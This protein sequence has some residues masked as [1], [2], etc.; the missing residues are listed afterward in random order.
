MLVEATHKHEIL[1]MLLSASSSVVGIIP[2]GVGPEE[3][4]N[5]PSL[6]ETW[7]SIEY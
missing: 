6:S 7:S 4:L 1:E 2:I 3:L 5:G